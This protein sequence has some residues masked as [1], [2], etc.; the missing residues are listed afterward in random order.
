MTAMDLISTL[1]TVAEEHT[2]ESSS[3]PQNNNNPVS[4]VDAD[5]TK[6]QQ[7]GPEYGSTSASNLSG[8]GPG[9]GG[10]GQ[11]PLNSPIITNPSPPPEDVSDLELKGSGGGADDEKLNNR[12]KE[13]TEVQL[14]YRYKFMNHSEFSMVIKPNN[15]VLR[16]TPSTT[17][18]MNTP[19]THS[20]LTSR[21]YSIT[22]SN[23]RGIQDSSPSPLKSPI[24]RAINT[25]RSRNRGSLSSVNSLRYS[26]FRRRTIGAMIYSRVSS[27]MSMMRS[28][29]SDTVWLVIG[30]PVAGEYGT[31]T[32][33]HRSRM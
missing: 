11:S 24:S 28:T 7:Q 8:N 33:A 21:S 1:T 6:R 3:D 30:F 32:R 9:H 10:Q 16:F 19:N 2:D 17:Y 4:S 31:P 18:T 13:R 20:L 14:G 26:P 12:G 29:I 25:L 23:D 22:S 5:H 15:G 27:P